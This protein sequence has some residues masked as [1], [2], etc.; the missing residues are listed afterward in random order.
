M[1]KLYIGLMSGT[2]IDAIDAVL[3]DFG[4]NPLK[5]IA[6]HS[7]PISQDLKERI[8]ALC[9]PGEDEINRM[10]QTDN[11]IGQIFAKAT[12]TLLEKNKI[13]AQYKSESQNSVPCAEH[14]GI[15]P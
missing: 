11:E 9:K 4:E 10:C 15:T 14:G 13:N 6:S 2:S 8:L 1:Q 7:E 3:V 12:N 5:Q